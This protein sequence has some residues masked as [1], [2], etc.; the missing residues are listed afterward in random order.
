[1]ITPSGVAVIFIHTQG[2]FD[3]TSRD[4]VIY[5]VCMGLSSF[6]LYNIPNGDDG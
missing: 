6:V 2:M 5:A 3:R 1:M 4:D